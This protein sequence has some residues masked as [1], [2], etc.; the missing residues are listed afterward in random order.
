MS[1]AILLKALRRK[2]LWREKNCGRLALP[3]LMSIGG[4]FFG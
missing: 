4:D 1:S 3:A 2:D